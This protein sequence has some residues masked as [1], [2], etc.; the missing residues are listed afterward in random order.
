MDRTDRGHHVGRCARADRLFP[1]PSAGHYLDFLLHK[2][3]GAARFPRSYGGRRPCGPLRVRMA[4]TGDPVGWGLPET[5]RPAE[6]PTAPSREYLSGFGETAAGP[7]P[8]AVW[9]AVPRAAR[10]TDSLC[11]IGRVCGKKVPHKSPHKPLGTD[12]CA[13]PHFTLWIFGTGA[14]RFLW[15]PT[16]RKPKWPAQTRGREFSIGVGRLVA[17]CLPPSSDR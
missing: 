7:S 4:E 10:V 15:P 3:P 1:R 14:G 9:S 2:P 11:F 6:D 12:P 5:R 13:R 16:W 8:V 17:A